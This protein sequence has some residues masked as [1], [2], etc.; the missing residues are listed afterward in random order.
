MSSTNY[1]FYV[2]KSSRLNRVPSKLKSPSPSNKISNDFEYTTPKILS[3][4]ASNLS[5]NLLLSDSNVNLKNESKFNLKVNRNLFKKKNALQISCVPVALNTKKVMSEVVTTN[6]SPNHFLSPKKGLITNRNPQKINIFA[7]T[8]R[9]QI[10]DS[11][12]KGKKIM[13]KP[14]NVLTTENI[15][16]KSSKEESLNENMDSD[17]EQS[18]IYLNSTQNE[19]CYTNIGLRKN[20]YNNLMSTKN[21]DNPTLEKKESEKLNIQGCSVENIEEVHLLMV[22]LIQQAKKFN[23]ESFD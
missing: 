13:L 18:S 21:S 6:T 7:K 3:K 19:Y 5:N 9:K 23:Y 20:K 17:K 15:N 22:S 12:I 10:N 11:E 8:F 16:I 2:Y 4:H 1:N 14:K